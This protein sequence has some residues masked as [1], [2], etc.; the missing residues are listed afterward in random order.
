[1]T[2]VRPNPFEHTL[3]AAA[4]A[5]THPCCYCCNEADPDRNFS[6]CSSKAAIVVPVASSCLK[7]GS[8][9]RLGS[10]ARSRKERTLEKF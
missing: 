9:T 2:S 1:M 5:R 8:S 10:L 3:L 6:S 4:A 7:D